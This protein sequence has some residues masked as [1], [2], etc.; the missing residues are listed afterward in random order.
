M[1]LTGPAF[2][3]V[4]LP[5]V[6][7]LLLGAPA[8]DHLNNAL[9]LSGTNVVTTGTN[10]DASRE[11]GEPN[12]AANLGGKSVWWKWTPPSAGS[13]IVQT[14]GSTFDTLLAAYTGASIASL[15][16]VASNDDNGSL[17][18]SAMAFNVRPNITYRIAVDGFGGASGD[19]QLSLAYRPG[20]LQAPANDH[21]ADRTALSGSLIQVEGANYLATR[22][23]EEPNHAGELGGAS[24]WWSWSAP[25]SGDVTI[26]TE[27]SSFDTL[28]AVYTGSVLTNLLLVARNDDASE[29][30]FTSR[31]LFPAT[32]D[33]TYHIA[34]DGFGRAVGDIH[35]QVSMQSLLRLDLP[36]LVAGGGFKLRLHGS[37]GPQFT[38]E[39]STDLVRWTPLATLHD[40]QG[41]LEY[42]DPGRTSQRFFRARKAAP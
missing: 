24:V 30:Q 35:L 32:A 37:A 10:V 20:Q 17:K 40:L 1:K 33:T 5:V 25:F 31:L 12:H 34:V 13:V 3:L 26:D 38:L 7:R 11:V 41:T 39:G 9:E 15:D 6:S 36:Q 23:S 22:E 19:I 27:G 28:L 18:T 42:T 8:N 4:L 16:A 14:T 21:F 29:N 2:A